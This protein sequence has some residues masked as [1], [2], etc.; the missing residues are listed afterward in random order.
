M[1]SK[2][3][4]I[5]LTK[6]RIWKEDFKYYEEI[7]GNNAQDWKGFFKVEALKCLE[8]NQILSRFLLCYKLL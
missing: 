4:F 6:E 2:L 8:Q 5:D 1:Y 3:H 7:L